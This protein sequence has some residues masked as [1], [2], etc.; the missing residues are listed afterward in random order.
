M[1]KFNIGKYDNLVSTNTY[2]SGKIKFE[3]TSEGTVIVADHQL[4]G[5]GYGENSW[6]SAKGKNLLLSVYLKPDFLAANKQFYLSMAVSLTLINVLKQRTSA[7][8]F[9]IK[10]PNDIYFGMKKIAGILIEN[11][12]MG[13]ALSDSIVGIGLNVNQL[14]FSEKLPN[15]ISM[16]NISGENIDRDSLLADILT[17]LNIHLSLI[18]KNEFELLKTNYYKELFLK[19]IQSKFMINNKITHGKIIGINDF[20]QL[21]VEIDK[22]IEV[23]G[24]KEIEYIL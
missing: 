14:N 13:D 3:N 7:N 10:W 8:D 15:P 4:T 6:E 5:K 16:I 20:G 9:K 12:I 11:T 21:K 22:K 1:I 17:E 23:F 19:G 24:F 18:A 2:L